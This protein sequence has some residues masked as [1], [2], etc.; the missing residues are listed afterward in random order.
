MELDNIGIALI[1]PSALYFLKKIYPSVC[2][3]KI[4]SIFAPSKVKYTL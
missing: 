3:S 1:L 2:N 4:L